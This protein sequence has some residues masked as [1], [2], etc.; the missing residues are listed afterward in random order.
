MYN[1]SRFLVYKIINRVNKYKYIEGG[2]IMAFK[3]EKTFNEAEQLWNVK[4]I[5]DVD[6]QSSQELKNDLNN[7]LD[8][9]ENNIK[10]DCENLSYIDSTGLGVLIG[11]LKRVKGTSNDIMIFNAQKNI[12]R[13]LSITGLDK[14][15]IVE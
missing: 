1:G 14:I 7:M 8:I 6:I 5:G 3:M 4:L 15:F 13:L 9:S 10:I 12:N 11:I 2:Y